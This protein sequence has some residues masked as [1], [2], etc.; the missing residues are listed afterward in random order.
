MTNLANKL[1]PGVRTFATLFS[2]Q[3]LTKVGSAA[4][5]RL[6]RL[7]SHLDNLYSRLSKAPCKKRANMRKAADRMLVRIRNLVDDLHWKTLAYMGDNYD[8]WIIPESDFTSAVKRGTRKIR[9]KTC[10]N[11]MTFSF[12][13]FRDRAL[14]KALELGKNVIL[15]DEAYTSK[16]HA[17]TGEVITNLGGRKTITSQRVTLDRDV[18]G[19]L[20]IF[21]KGLCGIPPAT[22]R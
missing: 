17:L 10:R 20:G 21:L 6:Q 18:N 13:R 2:P 9:S 12:A 3:G 4:F 15:V 11:L 8:T 5:G 16:T 22:A 7:C 14:A 1:D 19:A